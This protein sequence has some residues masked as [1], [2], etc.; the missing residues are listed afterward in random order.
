MGEST[1]AQ[2]PHKHY[3]NPVWYPRLQ[4]L[5][6]GD[7]NY[8]RNPDSSSGPWCYT[9]DETVVWDYCPVGAPA[10]APCN[11]T[12]PEA[13]KPNITHIALNTMVDGVAQVRAR[14]CASRNART[15]ACMCRMC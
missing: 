11:H 5:G 8:C 13:R 3:R 14:A 7:H 2:S 1:A 15:H 6:L 10:K 12:A 4:L 9:T